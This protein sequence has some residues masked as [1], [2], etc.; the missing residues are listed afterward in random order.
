MKKLTLSIAAVMAMGTFAV[1]GGDIAP[2]EPV[3]VEEVAP[4]T[5]S[6]FYF[7]L[8]YTYLNTNLDGALS[9]YNGPD[10]PADVIG[11]DIDVST[12]M[13]SFIAGYKINQ[14][15]AVEGR[16]VPQFL[17]ID[18]TFD[19]DAV[20]GEIEASNIALYAKGIYPVTNAFDIYALVGYGQTSISAEGTI[21]GDDLLDGIDA[22]R[23]D[24]GFQW[25]IGA[26]YA[27]SEHTSLFIDYSVMYND[28]DFDGIVAEINNEIDPDSLATDIYIDAFTFGMTYKF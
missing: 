18:G 20:D 5:D 1:A 26:A 8:G 4:V 14:Y 23:S 17:S 12:S 10:Q 21:D 27:L 2:V 11:F 22:D 19:G 7:G 13:T 25:G 28:S 3:I 15:F 16:Y 6:G 9:S 24:S